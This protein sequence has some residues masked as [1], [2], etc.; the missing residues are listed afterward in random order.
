MATDSDY[1]KKLALQSGQD[2]TRLANLRDVW[3]SFLG[4]T[5]SRIGLGQIYMETYS[6][7]GPGQSY[8]ETVVLD[9]GKAMG[10]LTVVLD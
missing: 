2:F 8:M 10:E 5:Y 1:L 9:Q 4:E 7:I 3:S 6:R